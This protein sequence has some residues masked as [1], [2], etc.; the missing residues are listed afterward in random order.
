RGLCMEAGIITSKPRQ[1]GGGRKPRPEGSA[2]VST[3]KPSSPTPPA[4]RRAG[5][6][7][8]QDR[9]RHEEDPGVDLRLIT[10]IIQQLPRGSQWTE[11][12]R[13]RRRQTRTAALDGVF[14]IGER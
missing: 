1:R 7:D 3:G 13:T 14:Y 11:A 9:H 5:P 12:R 10:A 8:G 6:E 2:K 4:G